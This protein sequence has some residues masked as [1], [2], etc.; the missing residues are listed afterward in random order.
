M[1]TQMVIRYARTQD[2]MDIP[3]ASAGT[4]AAFA[5]TPWPLTGAIGYEPDPEMDEFYAAISRR[6]RLVT[7]D[8][9]GHGRGPRGLASFSVDDRMADL[10][11]VLD[12]SDCESA[13]LFAGY[14]YAPAAVRFA[15]EHPHRV[16]ALILFGPQFPGFYRWP[17]ALT[18]LARSDW[19]EYV[20]YVATMSHGAASDEALRADVQRIQ[21]NLGQGDHILMREHSLEPH[22][23]LW[24]PQVRVPTL[25]LQYSH[26]ALNAHGVAERIPGSEFALLSSGLMRPVREQLA[27]TMAAIEEFLA[28]LRTRNGEP[29]D[30]NGARAAVDLT[31]RENEIL[32]L[33]AAGQSNA[34]I[35]DSL[36]LSERT[37][38]RHVA[39]IYAKLGVHNRVQA[40]SAANEDGTPRRVRRPPGPWRPDG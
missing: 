37:V 31:G 40:A 29:A 32:E 33:L 14:W 25:V 2:G 38:A 15:V 16:R 39:N 20:R 17:Q 26:P 10:V 8:G 21:A 19:P 1:T 4:G 11:A 22:S 12:A 7:Y 13:I 34:G 36:V 27:P 24:L 35:A 6:H 3:F 30:G 23:E 5:V 9:R 28:R 18:D